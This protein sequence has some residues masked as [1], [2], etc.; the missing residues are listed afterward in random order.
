LRV[1]R[2]I[3]T[4]PMFLRTLHG[5]VFTDIGA[6][7]PTLDGL[8]APALSI[9]AEIASD[10]TLGYSWGLTLVAGAAWT[11]EPGRTGRPDGAAVF[12]RTGYAF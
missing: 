2:G 11:H 3:S 5:A 10:L 1:E 4:W 6:A 12:V 8:P 7:G 9:G